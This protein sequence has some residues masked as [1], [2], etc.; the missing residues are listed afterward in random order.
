[1]SVSSLATA[2]ERQVD[3]GSVTPQAESLVAAEES[4]HGS[5]GPGPTTLLPALVSPT[6][7]KPVFHDGA[8]RKALM[9][10]RYVVLETLGTGGFGKVKRG[11]DRELKMPVALKVCI[12]KYGELLLELCALL[13]F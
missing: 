12:T 8:F 11:Y 13:C 7:A 9:N 6:W 3:R 10:R 1:M 4:G 5:A 2:F